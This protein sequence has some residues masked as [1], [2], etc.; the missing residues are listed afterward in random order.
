MGSSRVTGAVCATGIIVLAGY[1]FIQAKQAEK[2]TGMMRELANSTPVVKAK[3]RISADG[4]KTTFGPNTIALC[5]GVSLDNS[6]FLERGADEAVK[7]CFE[8]TAEKIGMRPSEA[9]EIACMVKEAYQ[10]RDFNYD[11]EKD[12][13]GIQNSN[14]NILNEWVNR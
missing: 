7:L 5:D 10:D 4:C 3:I 2:E 1:F 9:R 8:H 14:Y 12:T 13:Y 6:L 11:I